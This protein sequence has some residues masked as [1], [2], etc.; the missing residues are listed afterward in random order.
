MTNI[1]IFSKD[2]EHWIERVVVFILFNV[3]WTPIVV[4]GAI[5]K[6][7]QEGLHEYISHY[8]NWGWTISAI[9]FFVESISKITCSRRN[10][11]S[12]YAVGFLFWLAHG[13]AWLVFSLVFIMFAESTEV[14]MSLMVEHGGQYASGTVL[15]LERVFHVLPAIAL[16][17]YVF[18]QR[19]LIQWSLRILLPRHSVA[20]CYAIPWAYLSFILFAHLLPA[21]LYLVLYDIEEVYKMKTP[22]WLLAIFSLFFGLA[23]NGVVLNTLRKNI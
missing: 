17:F 6:L 3:I 22:F 16:L 18:L 10:I 4:I 13:T 8:T 15:D 14:V 19:R 5:Y 2:H 21:I 12:L 1:S 23:F 11:V 20:K 7:A 9:F